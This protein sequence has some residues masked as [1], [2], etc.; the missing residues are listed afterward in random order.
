M[1]VYT[2]IYIYIYIRKSTKYIGS[3]ERKREKGTTPPSSA[4]PTRCPWFLAV[5][6]R[7]KDNFTKIKKHVYIYIYRERYTHRHIHIERERKK[8]KRNTRE[9][10]KRNSTP[11]F[12]MTHALSLVSCCFLVENTQLATKPIPTEVRKQQRSYK[13]E[14]H[15]QVRH[16]PRAVP[17]VLLLPCR[18]HTT[19]NQTDTY[20]S[21]KTATKLQRGTTPPSSAWPTRCP[22]HWV[23]GWRRSSLRH[24][25]FYY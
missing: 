20:R 13:E 3:K 2:Y 1:Y 12:G 10:K 18:K 21:K 22:W 19:S 7:I 23:P 25:L 5:S 6:L 9:H 14:Q 8:K 15:P 4:W 16:G 11:K 24:V 17:G